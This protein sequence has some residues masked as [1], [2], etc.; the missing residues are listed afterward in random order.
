MTISKFLMATVALTMSGGVAAAEMSNSMT[1]GGWGGAY[2]A[3]Q[4]RAF[5]DPYVEM[6]PEVSY[7]WDERAGE[8]AAVLR[9]MN[10]AGNVTWDV[11]TVIAAD[12]IRLCDEG[13][14]AEIDFDNDL[15][16]APD[17]TPASEDFGDSLVSECLVPIDF[18]STTIGYRT[19]LVGDNPPTEI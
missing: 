9:S 1:L 13:L 12:A 6:Y 15:D 17:G 7:V 8:A 10:E 3:A 4:Q 2:Q 5:V 16:P 19:D 11:V 18:Y 14:A